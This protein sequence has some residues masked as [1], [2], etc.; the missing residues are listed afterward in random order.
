MQGVDDRRLG[1]VFVLE[2]PLV[3]DDADGERKRDI[4]QSSNEGGP[5]DRSYSSERGGIRKC[6]VRPRRGTPAVESRVRILCPSSA[7]RM[8]LH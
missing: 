7:N 6:C 1:V 8:D 2:V 4:I 3:S 5:G